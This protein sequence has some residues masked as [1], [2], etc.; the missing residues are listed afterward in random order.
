MNLLN[1]IIK[2]VAFILAI[3]FSIGA[4]YGQSNKGVGTR[5][6]DVTTEK[7]LKDNAILD[8]ESTSKGFFL[9]RMTTAQRDAIKKNMGKDNGLAVYNIDNDCVEYWSERA[10]KW[11]SLCGSL[12]PAKVD[13]EENS[14]GTIQFVGFGD[15]IN[16]K[17]QHEQGKAIDPNT[18]WMAVRLKVNQIGTYTISANSNN[19]YFFSGEGQFQSVGTYEVVL[20]GMGTPIKGYDSNASVKGDKLQFSLNGIDSKVCTNVEVLVTPAAL[21]FQIVSADNAAKGKY[22][23]GVGAT[24][25]KGNS[26]ELGIKVTSAGLATVTASNSTLGIK[27]FGS[28]N[29]NI[30]DT[31]L[32]LEPLLGDNIPKEN[33]LEIYKLT[34]EVNTKTPDN[35]INKKSA[36]VTVEETQ[37]SGMY[38]TVDFGKEPYYQG[39]ALTD[40]HIIELPIKVISSGKVN[41]YLK[42]GVGIDFEAKDVMLTLTDNAETIQKVVFKAVPGKVLPDVSSIPLTL[43]VVGKRSAIVGGNV[44]NLPLQLRP[45]AYTIDC[46]TITSNRGTIPNDKPVGES[47]YIKAK[48]NVTS[49][50]EYEINTSTAVEGILFSTTRN[51][52]KQVFT[53]RGVQDVALYAVDGKVIPKRKGEYAVNLVANDLSQATCS[54]FKIKV[55]YNDIN[56]LVLKSES[57]SSGSKTTESLFFSGGNRF[58]PTGTFAVSGVVKVTTYDAYQKSGADR[59]NLIKEI[60][61]GKY[62]FIVISG[63]YGIYYVNEN[64]ANALYNYT[65]NNKGVLWLLT[66]QYTA[67]TVTSIDY[68]K[69]FKGGGAMSPLGK[70]NDGLDLLLR[71]NNGKDFTA[72]NYPND[73]SY[74]MRVIDETDPLTKPRNG[75]TYMTKKG[76]G[77]YDIHW[78]YA[79]NITSYTSIDGTGT[80][81]K[82]IVADRGTEFKDAR[83]LIF[84]HRTYKNLIWAPVAALWYEGTMSTG[85]QTDY[86]GTPLKTDAYKADTTQ[87]GAFAANI[88]TALIEYVANK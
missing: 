37:L 13:L 80:N 68:V 7:N 77:K 69:A 43:S 11:M 40:K 63:Q 9:P 34:F 1:K 87:T 27:F 31:K 51:G 58:G 21:D 10:D 56:V 76:G 71:F 75:Y 73:K 20:K 24:L 16:G 81:F 70:S 50:G 72:T 52:K 6:T 66:P 86:S 17:P 54:N 59:D 2:H 67:N 82:P 64:F 55:G 3:I 42:G 22:N 12:P 62:N 5:I 83:G 61:E 23:V 74:N 46:S 15:L 41:L 29:V 14:C 26:I 4:I 8:L 19:G 53:K 60:N 78:Y 44:L 79:P 38:S 65:I 32:I 25:K 30:N 28:K 47:F 33:D 45:L 35:T 88:F 85:V 36:T 18:Q 48:V 39:D 49:P 57:S 84:V